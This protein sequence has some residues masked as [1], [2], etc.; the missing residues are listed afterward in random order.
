MTSNKKLSSTAAKNLIQI[1]LDMD[2]LPTD[3]EA[4]AEK[5]GLVQVSNSDALESIVDSVIAD[6][7]QAVQDVQNGEMKALGFLVGQMMKLSQGKAN[8]S[9]A[10]ELLKKKI[11]P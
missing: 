8:P 10:Q 4:F 9:V 2:E 6:N 7:Q 1:L 5:N 11:L 3:I